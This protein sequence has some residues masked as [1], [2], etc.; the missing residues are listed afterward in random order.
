MRRSQLRQLRQLL[1][2]RARIRLGRDAPARDGRDRLRAL[3]VGLFPR[4]PT[5]QQETR[6]AGLLRRQLQAARGLRRKDAGLSHNRAQRAAAQSFLERPAYFCIAPGGDEDEPPQIKAEGGKARGIEI[7][8]LRHPGDPSRRRIGFQKQREEAGTRR[9]LFLVS[10][11]AGNFMDSAQ[12][13][14][15]SAQMIVDRIHPCGKHSGRCTTLR[16]QGGDAGNTLP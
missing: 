14:G 6:N 4:P 3:L 9:A 7:G 8:T 16:P 1:I 10:T 11:P 13:N 5:S 15:S 12:R 2:R